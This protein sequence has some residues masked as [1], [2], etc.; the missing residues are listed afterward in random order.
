MLEKLK[1]SAIVEEEYEFASQLKQIINNAYSALT[2]A[3]YRS[4]YDKAPY[5][6]PLCD[7]M[8]MKMYSIRDFG[9]VATVP[10]YEGFSSKVNI[11]HYC[12]CCM[13]KQPAIASLERG[14]KGAAFS[15]NKFFRLDFHCAE[16]STRIYFKP[17]RAFIGLPYCP[18]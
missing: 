7:S 2:I 17:Q 6:V 15:V 3:E 8:K 5:D 9:Y 12:V 18:R 14:S 10:Y 4:D 11:S 16:S 1:T 13:D